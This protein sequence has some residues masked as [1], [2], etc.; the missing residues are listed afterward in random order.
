MVDKMPCCQEE[1]KS[2]AW[3]GGANPRGSRV[4]QS[5]Y[6]FTDETHGWFIEF[7]TYNWF[8]I[9]MITGGPYFEK[10]SHVL[11]DKK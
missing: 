11:N 3:C 1:D 7:I 5:D 4:S 9:W 6:A 8:I 10:Q 2:K